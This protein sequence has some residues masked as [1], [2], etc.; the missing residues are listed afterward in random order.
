MVRLVFRPYTKVRRSICTSESKRTS[1]RVSSGFVLP[2]HSSPS[3]GSQRVHYWCA[4]LTK[5]DET[6]PECGLVISLRSRNQT[7]SVNNQKDCLHLHSA[8]GF[9]NTQWLAHMLNSLVR[10]SRRIEWNKAQ[11]LHSTTSAGEFT[12]KERCPA[13]KIGVPQTIHQSR[14]SFTPDHRRGWT[15]EDHEDHLTIQLPPG[16]Q[17]QTT[18][19]CSGGRGESRFDH[20]DVYCS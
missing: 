20:G 8:F 19:R 10:V 13:P 15:E 1:T 2:R 7:S 6:P 11:T 14:L 18:T 5:A 12:P 16:S 4:S 3:F 17:D 9:Q